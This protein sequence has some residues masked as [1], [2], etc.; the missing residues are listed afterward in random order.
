MRR[1]AVL[2]VLGVIVLVLIL[3]QLFLPGIAAQ[4]LRDRLKNNGTVL[5]VSVSA[6]PAIELLWHQADKVVIRMGEYRS[7]SGH[8]G[9]LLD[10]A[11]DVG[12]LNASAGVLTAGLLTLRDATLTKH[13]NELTGS[14]RITEADLKAS[15]PFLDSVTPVASGDGRLVLRGTATVLGVTATIDATV[16]AVNG[17]LIVQPDV[18]LG[19]LATVTVFSDPHVAVQSVGASPTSTGFSVSA[20]ARLH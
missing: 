10:Q 4:Q 17:A 5:Q 14:A 12:S 7:S 16:A 9:S 1:I 20:D 3:A 2:S 6:F 19:A 11:G 13:G 8:L 18:P 15:V